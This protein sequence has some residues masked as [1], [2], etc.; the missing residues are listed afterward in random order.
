M[1]PP[2]TRLGWHS[3][4]ASTVH[5]DMIGANAR[6]ANRQAASP[7]TLPAT[8]PTMSHPTLRAT[9]LMMTTV[10]AAAP[11]PLAA[12]N[13]P[14]TARPGSPGAPYEHLAVFEGTWREVDAPMDRSS[15]D[16]CEWLAGGHR[17]MICRR[18][19]QTV[20][21][22]REHMMIYSYRRSDSTFTSTVFLSGGQVWSYSG[23]P[24]GNRWVF[25]LASSRSR[26]PQRLRQVI[27]TNADTLHFVEEVSENDGPWKLTDPSEDYK[28]VRVRHP[29]Q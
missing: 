2:D 1:Q 28:Y 4:R 14:S 18:V 27:T 26:Q 21:G 29:G 19:T 7:T 15:R 13:T 11:A 10:L 17:H 8:M 24:E 3:S 23:R 9:V 25:Y 5:Q 20:S 6:R 22:P 16:T 12:Q